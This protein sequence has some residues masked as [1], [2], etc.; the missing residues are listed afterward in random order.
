MSPWH[1]TLLGAN[2]EM[3]CA[4]SRRDLDSWMVFAADPREWWA[5]EEVQSPPAR[6]LTTEVP[7]LGCENGALSFRVPAK[8]MATLAVEPEVEGAHSDRFGS[9]APGVTSTTSRSF[10]FFGSEQH[11][12]SIFHAT[13]QE[14]RHPLP[15]SLQAQPHLL[16]LRV[17]FTADVE[18]RCNAWVRELL[19]GVR[20]P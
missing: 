4:L 5:E 6:R 8:H 2:L 20:A 19:Q 11:V 18:V 16:P 3:E 13:V 14:H 7:D 9:V 17:C 1:A 12:K 15:R 10:M